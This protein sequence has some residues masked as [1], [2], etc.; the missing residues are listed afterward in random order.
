MKLVNQF[1]TVFYAIAFI[2]GWVAIFAPYIP[3]NRRRLLAALLAATGAGVLPIAVPQ[4]LEMLPLKMLLELMVRSALDFPSAPTLVLLA[5]CI[6][7]LGIAAVLAGKVRV[8]MPI[9]SGV[10]GFF[11]APVVWHSA[12]LAHKMW[13]T[14]TDGS[15][16]NEDALGLA[17]IHIVLTGTFAV[18]TCI[19]W[20]RFFTGMH[21]HLKKSSAAS[22]GT[23]VAGSIAF[24]QTFPLHGDEMLL[25][26]LF[27][28]PAFIL[29]AGILLLTC[30]PLLIVIRKGRKL[31]GCAMG[32]PGL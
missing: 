6:S 8:L 16:D 19:L 14:Y 31:F 4:T 11:A 3:A 26:W 30:V 13:N 21:S 15:I 22:L 7:A 32:G 23:F 18:V 9:L 28:T 5:M 17:W 10:Y 29:A 12:V 1:A 20:Y 25:L 27:I 2:A 24:V